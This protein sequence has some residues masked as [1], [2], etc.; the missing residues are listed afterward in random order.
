[1]RFLGDALLSTPLVHALKERFPDCAVDVLTFAGTEAAFEGNRDVAQVIVVPEAATSMQTLRQALALWRHYDLAVIAQTGTRPF[2]FGWAGGRHRLGLVVPDLGKSWWKRALLHDYAVFDRRAARVLENQRLAQLLGVDALPI[3]VPPTAGW[4]A[5][6]IEAALGFDPVSTRFAIVHP[7]PRW[8]YKQWTADGWRTLVR[9]LA[10]QGLRVV[11][12]GGPGG[13]EKAYLDRVLAGLDPGTFLRV[14]GRWSFAQTA[15]VLRHALLYVGPDTA[16]THLAAAC[17]TPV[18]ALY[19]PT[20]PA[21]W[22]P[23]PA[24][25]GVAYTRVAMQQRRSNV[26]LLQNPELSCVPCQL[27]GCERHRES[28]SQ[29]LDRLPAQ[30]VIVAASKLLGAPR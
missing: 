24:R 13:S 17:G 30:R 25:E 8:R 1:M 16:T 7:A 12:T 29:C 10:A 4:G 3:V 28:Y 11:I 9:A 23:W 22:G 5:R 21:L 15:D 27:E 6:E 26:I 18:L 2:L 19:G 14:D 20:D